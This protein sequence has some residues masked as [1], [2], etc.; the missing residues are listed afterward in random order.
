MNNSQKD[1][2]PDTSED[3]NKDKEKWSCN[4]SKIFETGILGIELSSV[5]KFFEEDRHNIL[6]SR[7]IS[8][9]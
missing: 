4:F 5:Y 8:I 9:R 1:K 7:L 2:K 6:I 3:E